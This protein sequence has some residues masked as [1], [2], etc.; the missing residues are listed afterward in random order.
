M[1]VFSSKKNQWRRRE[2]PAKLLFGLF[3]ASLLACLILFSSTSIWAQE[4]DAIITESRNRPFTF[5]DEIS[6]STERKDFV[7]LF[8][9]KNPDRQAQ[10][11]EA[12]L[13][14]F[15]AS[16]VLAQVSE[17][18]A[19]AE[20][21]LGNYVKAMKYA[22]ESLQLYPENPLLLVPLANVQAKT[23]LLDEAQRNARNA[24]DYL[25]R[26][27]RPVAIP[28]HQWP[29]LQRQ[30]MS[31]CYFV[32]GRTEL[33]QGLKL[34]GGNERL[35]LL[36]QALESLS[37][38]Q[39][40]NPDDAEV[41]Y[42]AGL[43][44]LAIGNK[45]DAATQFARAAQSRDDAIRPR[46]LEEL[47]TLYH[48]SGVDQKMNFASYVESLNSQA[49][50]GAEA[51]QSLPAENAAQLP[52]YA[53]SQAC[54]TCH[55]DIYQNWSHTGMAG[56]FR[57][58]HPQNII[59][60]FDHNDEFYEGDEVRLKRDGELEI[61]PGKDRK[62][63][64][65]MIMVHGRPYFQ[66]RQS[67]GRWNLYRVDYTIGSKWEQ[68]YATELPNGEIHVFPIQY[69]ALRKRWINF[70]KVIDVPGSE[71]SNPE[72]WERLDISTNYKANCAACH[73]SQLRNTEGGGFAAQGLEFR[74]PG[75]DCEMCHGPSAYHVAMM[76]KGQLYSK[77]PIEPPVDFTKISS[78]QF[79]EICSQCHM[80]SAIRVPGPDGELNYSRNGPDFFKHYKNRPYDE[81]S[82]KAFYRDGRFRQT[83]FIVESLMRSECYLKGHVTCGSCHDPHLPNFSSN[84]TS[85]KY[86][87]D[88]DR[89]CTQCHVQ[90]RDRKQVAQH[91]HHS[92][93]SKGSLCVSCHMPRIMDSMLFWARTHRIDNIPNPQMTLRFGEHDSPNACLLCHK[94]KNAQWVAATMTAWKAKQ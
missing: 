82:K 73:T 26:F 11:A 43:S 61:I 66:I 63:F 56:M 90:F 41:Q 28:E 8:H 47:T 49:Q 52:G 15:P 93:G 54:K 2:L 31:S 12:F 70:W 92:F 69:N 27:G 48:S 81:F 6:D 72:N 85:L 1:R 68:A 13:A 77:P 89:M 5:A 65:K 42:L 80:Q 36:K 94:E 35:Q 38:A 62:L 14:R 64:A 4:S 53:G 60:D 78:T 21:Q 10:L 23:G 67:D 71:R 59:G 29:Q 45:Q 76:K 58:Y 74:E 55:A 19:K 30:L 84:L 7:E 3:V 87:Q 40:L 25:S 24:L 91:T 22:D 79:L 50:S 86:P 46:A 32:L 75:I 83:T 20:I 33:L 34:G 39:Q 44:Y 37:R 9:T 16:T 18:A 51:R 57:P 17:I 88:P